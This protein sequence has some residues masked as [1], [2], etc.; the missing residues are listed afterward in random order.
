MNE[1]T[2]AN[3]QNEVKSVVELMKNAGSLLFVDYLGLTVAEVSELR[4]KLHAENCQMKV[5]KNNI[6]RRA[7]ADAGFDVPAENFIG[8]SAA[9]FSADEV[10]GSK[11]VF[12]FAKEHDKIQVKGGVVDS[13]VMSV[14]DLK[15]LSALPNKDG[16]ISMLLS[17]MQAPIRGLACAIK[18][19]SEKE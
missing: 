5:I 2:I 12:G 6:L 1:A 14:A 10:T 13:Q 3:K 15:V 9:I 17:V 18:A 19:V 7:A 8:P 16:M 4:S 11:I